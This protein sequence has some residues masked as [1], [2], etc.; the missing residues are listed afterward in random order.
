MLWIILL[1]IS[2]A[3]FVIGFLKNEVAIAKVGSILFI[4]PVLGWFFSCAY[5]QSNRIADQATI[6]SSSKL[7]SLSH[8][9]ETEGHLH[10]Q[11]FLRV[12]GYIKG[13]L[14]EESYYE[15]IVMNGDTA[16]IKKIEVD[17]VKI[18]F[19]DENEI[20]PHIEEYGYRT[21]PAE[22]D[23]SAIFWLTIINPVE[24]PFLDGL[25]TKSD[26]AKHAYYVIYVPEDSISAEYNLMG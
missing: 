14:K 24:H 22:I 25:Q 7:V 13:E 15:M 1:I 18:K 3:L 8:S 4:L 10:G 16:E 19:I 12:Y 5:Y 9:K 6:I 23:S 2:I 17:D 20:E 21:F 11:S 26:S